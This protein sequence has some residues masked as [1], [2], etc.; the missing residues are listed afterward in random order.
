M[1]L[2]PFYQRR[3]CRTSP[4][5]E[6]LRV[7]GTGS[8]SRGSF[9]RVPAAT[10]A[11][12]PLM[13]LNLGPHGSGQLTDTVRRGK[14]SPLSV[15]V[16]RAHGDGMPAA[17]VV[18]VDNFQSP[19]P[20]RTLIQRGL[21]GG[22]VTREATNSTISMARSTHVADTCPQ[23]N[24]ENLCNHTHLKGKWSIVSAIQAEAS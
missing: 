14:V 15:S 7:R 8:W 21:P 4:V 2:S 23:Q 12:Y 1:S 22:S 10:T 18:C 9:F 19:T 3:F 11:G 17:A 6:V 20:P 13:L 5:N 16:L 24:Y